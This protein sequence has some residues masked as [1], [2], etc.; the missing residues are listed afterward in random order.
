MIAKYKHI[1]PEG[2]LKTRLSDYAPA[3]FVD[4]IPSRKGVKKAIDRGAF[5]V[6]GQLGKTGT[7]ITEG[8]CIELLELEK[9]TKKVFKLPLEVVYEDAFFAVI[10]KP[11]GVMVNGNSFRTI[12]NALPFNLKPSQ[13]L[14]ALTNPRVVHRLDSAT[15]GLLLVAKTRSAHMHLGQQFEQHSIQKIYKAVT[16]GH[17]T[18][19]GEIKTS[20]DQKQALTNYKTLEKVDSKFHGALAL[21]E[22]YPKTGRTHQLRIHLA[23]L[24]CPILGDQLYGEEGKILKGKG[25]FLCAVGLRFEH[26]KSG[27][28]MDFEI[29]EPNKF[30]RFMK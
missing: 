24:D 15:S 2:T 20:V 25:L 21:L 17:P 23:S 10:N 4:Y 30:R 9:S 5:R 12:E 26:P 29:A 11:A 28:S 7:W 8:Q 14:D 13:E 3:V 27:L 16:V 19:K 6:D 22:L 18:E 1:V